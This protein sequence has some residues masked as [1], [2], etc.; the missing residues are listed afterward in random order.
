V[1]ALEEG[2]EKRHWRRVMLER[3]ALDGGIDGAGGAG[4]GQDGPLRGPIV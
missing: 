3:A 1:E 4:E 2:G